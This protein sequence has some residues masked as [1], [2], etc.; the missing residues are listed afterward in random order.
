MQVLLLTDDVTYSCPDEASCA[1]EALRECFVDFGPTP[2]AESQLAVFALNNIS[3][4]ELVLPQPPAF[5]DESCAD[6][7]VTDMPPT[8]VP[9]YTAAGFSVRF[10]PSV[11]S[12]CEAT[13]LLRSD[14][15]NIEG[16]ADAELRLRGRGVP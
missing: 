11:A 4:V 15:A 9:E 13:L 3:P 10:T 12:T 7:D 2:V 14:T 6:F 5:T 16:G 8:V 1:L